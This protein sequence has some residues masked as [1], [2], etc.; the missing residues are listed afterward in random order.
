MSI[1]FEAV[2][3]MSQVIHHFNRY[4]EDSI[5]RLNH[6]Y[7]VIVFCILA[8]VVTT[9]QYVGEIIKCWAPAQFP[10]SWVEY[11]NNMCW[12]SN[13]YYIPISEHN[14][15]SAPRKEIVYY[16]WVPLVLFLQ[17]FMFYLPSVHWSVLNRSIGMDINKVV[18]TLRQ[19]DHINPDSRDKVTKFI[20]KHIDRSLNY[21][22]E[23]RKGACA[24]FK[25][26]MAQCG[27]FCGKRYGNFLITIYLVTKILY[28]GDAVIQLYMLNH[29]LGTD[30]I[31]YG[32]DVIRDLSE[33]GYY[34]ESRRF[35]KSTL[36]DFWI[37]SI[38]RTQPH[39]IQCT[40]PVNLFNEKIFIF[41]WF[42]LVTLV[43]VNF[44]SLI[45]WLWIAFTTN[46]RDYLKTYLKAFGKYSKQNDQARLNTFSNAYLRQDGHF[47]LRMVAKN[48]N[49][50]VAGELVTSLWEK[51]CKTNEKKQQKYE[52]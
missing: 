28:L 50:V 30:Y 42:W 17:A 36:C 9:N 18:Q 49:G 47:M 29:F 21:T 10:D 39:T 37:R 6:K 23:I 19:L 22:R 2:E 43:L 31:F 35:P 15:L 1:L 38:G 14:I 5:D 51:F 46:R 52:V 16:Q 44:L 11:T 45:Y 20:I 13:T 27:C 4:D 26:R 33:T 34:K 25:Q 12:I 32:V 3:P 24:R 48:T 40:L 41:V 8:I 7:S